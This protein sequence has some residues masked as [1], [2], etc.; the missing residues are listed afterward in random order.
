[1]KHVE[2]CRVLLHLVDG[3]QDDVAEAYRIVRAEL[4][5]YSPTLAQ[6]PEILALNK[7]DALDE[8]TIAERA[9]ALAAVSGKEVA[10]ISGVSGKGVRETLGA[11]YARIAPYAEEERS[12]YADASDDDT[13][14]TG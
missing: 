1:L 12:L 4:D 11:L 5:A 14:S 9:A 7:C 2:R 8:E 13:G 6:K 3:T 10:T